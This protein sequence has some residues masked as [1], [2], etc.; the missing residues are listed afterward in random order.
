MTEQVPG[1][2]RGAEKFPKFVAVSPH[3]HHQ[4]KP[5]WLKIRLTANNEAYKC[6]KSIIDQS[7]LHT[8]CKEASC[9]N[10]Y[11]CLASGVAS[12][13]IMGDKCTR[14]CPFCDVAYG[15]PDPLDPDEPEALRKT[16]EKL[17]L[18][19]VV[20]TSVDRDDLKD[21]GASHF[22]ACVRALRTLSSV[23]V[24]ILVPDFRG[25]KDLAVQNLGAALPDVLSHNIE[26][27]PRLYRTVKPGALYTHSLSLLQD[28]KRAYPTVKTK[29][30]L[31]VGIGETMD[32]ISEVLTDLR[33]HGV[34]L[35]T[36]G[37]YLPPSKS[38]VP[39]S[40]Y[41]TPD[42]FSAIKEKALALGFLSCASGPFVRSSYLAEKYHR[43]A[44]NSE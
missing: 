31:M 34:E 4:P 17:R 1:K 9:P 3:P 8:V 22:A 39:A 37:Q 41:Y 21:G 10:I 43:E 7:R 25:R 16:V 35:L 26:T 30:G 27:V 42:E 6:S 33:E 2:K 13:L 18:T 24:E 19:Y 20:V 29:S 32:E 5:S 14:R 15:H 12:F 38:H 28:F 44:L 36:V 40:H 11:E 23:S